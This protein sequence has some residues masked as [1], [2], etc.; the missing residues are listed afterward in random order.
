VT[1]NG[2]NTN[3]TIPSSDADPDST[4]ASENQNRTLDGCITKPIISVILA[5]LIIAIIAAILQTWPNII[6]LLSPSTMKPTEIVVVATQTPTLESTQ[7]DLPPPTSTATLPATYTP[8]V[9][10]TPT[11]TWTDA[12]TLTPTATQT[13]SNTTSTNTFLATPTVST[14]ITNAPFTQTS[15]LTDVSVVQASQDQYPCE[16]TITGFSGLLNQVHVQPLANSPS[17]PPVARSSIIVI[18]RKEAISEVVWYQI[19]YQD[20]S[21]W[22]DAQYVSPGNTCPDT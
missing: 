3:T 17:R 18:L 4:D 14:T 9:T 19:E 16:G 2:K 12:P 1:K 13:P 11:A 22:I 8:Y 20:T 6:E 10:D 21:G 7:T 5:P 15:A